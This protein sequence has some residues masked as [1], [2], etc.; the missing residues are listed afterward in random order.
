M[1]ENPVP[2][3]RK[4]DSVPVETASIGKEY[5]LWAVKEIGGQD[6]PSEGPLGPKKGYRI[7]VF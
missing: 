2:E 4:V 6:I 3:T 5:W 1:E 7:R